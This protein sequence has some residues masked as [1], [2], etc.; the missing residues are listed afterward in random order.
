M[1]RDLFSAVPYTSPHAPAHAGPLLTLFCQTSP[2][3][4]YDSYIESPE[5]YVIRIFVIILMHSNNIIITH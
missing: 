2:A 5:V 1:N 4:L 3:K